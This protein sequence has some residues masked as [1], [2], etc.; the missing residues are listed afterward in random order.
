MYPSVAFAPPLMR[1]VRLL[2]LTMK[3]HRDIT[4][5]LD[6]E[7]FPEKSALFNAF[8]E[9]LTPQ[10]A[11]EQLWMFWETDYLTKLPLLRKIGNDMGRKHLNC[12][13]DLVSDLLTALDET[14]GREKQRSLTTLRYFFNLTTEKN[15]IE[16]LR[17]LLLSDSVILHRRAKQLLR[18]VWLPNYETILQ[19]A[20]TRHQT[21]DIAEIVILRLDSSFLKDNFLVLERLIA[22]S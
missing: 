22:Y 10:K 17:A 6:K 12:H 11:C 4:R 14:T 21:P 15:R 9:C 8:L 1:Y 18:T 20:R 7:Y 16:I 13:N 3:H 5:F 2:R 19:E